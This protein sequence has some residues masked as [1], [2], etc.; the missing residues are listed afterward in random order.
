MLLAPVILQDEVPRPMSM[1]DVSRGAHSRPLP[2]GQGGRH[3]HVLADRIAEEL[4]GPHPVVLEG[5]AGV[6][7]LSCQG[8]EHD[9]LTREAPEPHSNSLREIES[10]APHAASQLQTRNGAKAKRVTGK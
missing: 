2:H 10:G 1:N 8:P 3:A 9:A 6:V 7:L 4:R 5:D